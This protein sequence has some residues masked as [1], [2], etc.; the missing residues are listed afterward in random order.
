MKL[1]HIGIAVKDLNNPNQIS[2]RLFGKSSY[3]IEAVGSGR[4]ST[5]FFQIGTSKVE[6]PEATDKDSA[7]AKKKQQTTS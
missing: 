3:K 4:I 6:L 1:G 2:E 5:S 7:I